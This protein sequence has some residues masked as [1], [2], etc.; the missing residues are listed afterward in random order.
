MGACFIHD[1][2]GV[3]IS[4]VLSV[5]LKNKYFLLDRM[6]GAATGDKEGKLH[7]CQ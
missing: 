4:G 1:S 3:G 7:T 6:T 5:V 2:Q